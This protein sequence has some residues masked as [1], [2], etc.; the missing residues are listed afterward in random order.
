LAK[1]RF[2]DHHRYDTTSILAL[3]ESRWRLAPLSDRD[4]AAENMANVFDSERD[5]RRDSRAH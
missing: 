2:V 1:R 5:D 3:I 4:A